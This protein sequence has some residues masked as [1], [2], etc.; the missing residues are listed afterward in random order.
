MGVTLIALLS[1]YGTI[2]L[3]YSYLAIFVRPVTGAQVAV[4]EGQLE[5]VPFAAMQRNLGSACANAYH[6][7]GK[8]AR[9]WLYEL[10]C[11]DLSYTNCLE[12]APM[13]S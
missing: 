11:K 3:P 12:Q 7:F 13:V 6:A 9:H 5:Q 4:I 8:G 10:M 1:G 2:S